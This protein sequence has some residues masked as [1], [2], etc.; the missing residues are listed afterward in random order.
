MSTTNIQA[1]VG[2]NGVNQRDD[3]VL[4]QTLLLA[5]GFAR[6]GDA[7]GDCGKN[8]IAAILDFQSNF[9][10]N[11]DG[12]IDPGGTSWRNLAGTYPGLVPA[13]APA[14]GAP[15]APP[16]PPAAAAKTAA[17]GAAAITGTVPRPD[18]ASI[19]VG[20]KF[21]SNSFMLAKIG[22]PRDSYSQLC[23]TPTLPLL[24]RNLVLD[25][26]GPF[27]VTGLVP[28]V[29]SLKAVMIDIEREQPAVYRA[30][31]TAGM[32][33]CRWVRGSTTA[34]S[35]HSWGTA[36]DLTLNGVLDVYGNNQVQ[37]GLTLIAP[38]FNRHGWFW[39]AAFRTE[40]GMHFEA[41][42]SLIQQWLPSLR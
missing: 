29:L 31:G 39:G 21:V 35:N 17:A 34:I 8:T 11:P 32:L 20:L 2:R 6:V 26:V 16:A 4:V 42:E 36:I 37:R 41:S 28:A 25:S 19:N 9:L 27:R 10:K 14:P 38:I 15:P 12:R 1:S 3:V 7:D 13:T 24:R 40:D 18:A 33:C 23:Q 5:R 30:L 22:N